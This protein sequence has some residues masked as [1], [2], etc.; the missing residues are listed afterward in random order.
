MKPFLIVV[1]FLPLAILDAQIEHFPYTEDFDSV[2]I[3]SLPEGWM[4]SSNRLTNGDFT[5]T[6]SVPYSSPAAVV[7][8]NATIEQELITPF[9]D[10]AGAAPESLIF[11]ERRSGT[12]NSDLTI[13]GSTDG[14]SSFEVPIG[15]TLK[16]P[17][18]TA[19][20]RRAMFLPAVLR[21]GL[22]RLRWVVRGNGS[23]TTGTIRF[24]NVRITARPM[25]DLAI[26]SLSTN[27]LQA[28]T[29]ESITVR[30]MIRNA[31]LRPISHFTVNFYLDT[32]RNKT[33]EPEELFYRY[34][35]N[36]PLNENDSTEVTAPLQPERPG[37]W[38]IIAVAGAVED[39]DH[40]D[41]TMETGIPVGFRA[42]SVVINEI[43]YEPTSGSGEYVELY[44]A[45]PHAVDFQNWR[46]SDKAETGVV[47]AAH[48]ISRTSVTLQPA[49][50]LVV[51]SDSSIY[52]TFSYLRSPGMHV[53]VRSGGMSLNN[54][55]DE[56][57]LYD[58]ADNTIDSLRYSPEWHNPGVEDVRG[59]SLER[60]NPL[61]ASTDKHNWTTSASPDGGT[62]CAINSVYTKIVPSS[63][64]LAAAPNPFSPDGDGF[65]DMTMISYHLPLK[66]GIIRVRIYDS[67]GRLVRVLADGAP[68]GS[69]GVIVW[70]GLNDRNERVKIGIYLIFL[71]AFDTSASEVVSAKGVVV[72]ATK[73]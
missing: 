1:L 60:I 34:E 55:G 49:Q 3:P 69:S 9:L 14:G 5:T 11:Y 64:T 2:T 45:S 61:L 52:T 35:Q 17:G 51:V 10:V 43:M 59:R 20:I 39:N 7:S 29:G 8:T 33:A 62:P 23:G 30:A 36:E 41:D 28:Q 56:V 44:N 24:D 37:L 53:I 71:E 27:P 68:A 65:E 72:V 66:S 16:N 12:H 46:L 58:F 6:V 25:I 48:I 40:T 22:V 31:G 70:N 15:D 32:S 47:V 18:T 73:L 42:H 13:D 57:I 63:A 67:L 50:F 54:S 21:Q 38:G 4:S 19:Y 26:Q